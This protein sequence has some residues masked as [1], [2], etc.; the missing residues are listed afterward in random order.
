MS[1]YQFPFVQ[2]TNTN[3]TLEKTTRP[4]DVNRTKPVEYNV[5]DILKTILGEK[6]K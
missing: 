5:M 3:K 1:Y 6:M 2:R 4:V